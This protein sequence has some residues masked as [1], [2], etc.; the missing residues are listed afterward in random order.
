M[1]SLH[2]SITSNCDRWVKRF[3]PAYEIMALFVPRKLILKPHMR[4]HP[5]GLDI[6][7][8][9]GPFV[10]FHT[11][12]VRTAKALARLRGRV[13]SPGPSLVAYVISTI[14][15]WAGSNL[16]FLK[17]PMIDVGKACRKCLN[18]YV[19]RNTCVSTNEPPHDRTSKMTVSGLY[20]TVSDF[21]YIRTVWSVFAVRIHV[22]GS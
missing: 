14:I 15:S 19:K 3:E 8:L 20:I 9:V 7:F 17:K 4:S 11:S 22:S 6:W 21:D 16:L 5:V 12:C 18:S 13:G 1:N 2:G 10:Y